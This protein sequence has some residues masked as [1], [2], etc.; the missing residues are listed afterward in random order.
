MYISKHINKK[1][2][3]WMKMLREIFLG[4]FNRSLS[5]KG[6]EY[7]RLFLFQLNQV[8]LETDYSSEASK[9]NLNIL[10]LPA[11]TQ[12]FFPAEAVE[13]HGSRFTENLSKS[14]LQRPNLRQKVQKRFPFFK[15]WY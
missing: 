2:T 6:P 7:Q 8:L 1:K 13:N 14:F 15:H 12:R 3:A 10:L 11:F 4:I 9:E 5:C